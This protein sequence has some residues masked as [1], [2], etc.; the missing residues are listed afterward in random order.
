MKKIM[1]DMKNKD[2]RKKYRKYI[3][4]AFQN[5]RDPFILKL[6]K[7]FRISYD[8]DLRYIDDDYYFNEGGV[9]YRNSL[10]I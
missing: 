1:E 7:T 8:R 5:S 9:A 6:E 4:G 2:K 10:L 3:A